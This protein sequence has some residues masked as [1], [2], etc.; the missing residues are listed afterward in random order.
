MNISIY[1]LLLDINR[2]IQQTTDLKKNMDQIFVVALGSANIAAGA[3][4]S[5]SFAQ[6]NG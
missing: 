2:A 1:N 5:Q 6:V 3:D 4:R